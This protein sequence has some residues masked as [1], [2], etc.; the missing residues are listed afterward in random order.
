MTQIQYPFSGNQGL[1]AESNWGGNPTQWKVDI[2]IASGFANH[3]CTVMNK[4]MGI[5]VWEKRE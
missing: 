2:K 4:L 1:P 5:R 3:D